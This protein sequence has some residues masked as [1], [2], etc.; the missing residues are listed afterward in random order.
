[1]EL[2]FVAVTVV[3][4]RLWTSDTSSRGCIHSRQRWAFSD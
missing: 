2:Q 3:F 1:M 4:I